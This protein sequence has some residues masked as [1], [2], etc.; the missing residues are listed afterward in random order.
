MNNKYCKTLFLI[1]G[2]I[3]LGIYFIPFAISL[4]WFIDNLILFAFNKITWTGFL[5]LIVDFI[6]LIRG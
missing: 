5:S 6:N 2:G 1:L 3:A 4:G